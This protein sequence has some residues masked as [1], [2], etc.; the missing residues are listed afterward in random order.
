MST[1]ILDKEP[2]SVTT[3]DVY[4]E[5][6]GWGSSLSPSGRYFA[7]T[8]KSENIVLVDLETKE[9]RTIVE[10]TSKR[11]ED[12]SWEGGYVSFVSYSPDETEIAYGWIGDS[13]GSIRIVNAKTGAV[14]T[15]LDV[16]EY[17]TR[18]HDRHYDIGYSEAYALDW[19][20]DGSAILAFVNLTPKERDPD[21]LWRPL[22]IMVP[23]DGSTPHV[24]AKDKGMEKWGWM[25]A[26][27]AGGNDQYVMTAFGIQGQ[28]WIQ[29][30]DVKTGEQVPWRKEDDISI[31]GVACPAHEDKVV[32]VSEYLSTPYLM[33]GSVEEVAS[34]NTDDLITS[35]DSDRYQVPAFSDKGDLLIDTSSEAAPKQI[36]MDANPETGS[37]LGTTTIL[38]DGGSAGGWWDPSGTRFSWATVGEIKI[39]DKTTG[40][41][42]VL[43]V[44]GAAPRW[45]RWFPDGSK[46]GFWGTDKPLEFTFSTVYIETGEQSKSTLIEGSIIHTLGA[47]GNSLLV[48]DYFEPGP[49][50]ERVDLTTLE[51]S[52]YLCLE[53]DDS[54]ITK[55]TGSPDYSK[56]LFTTWAEES[57]SIGVVNAD[58]TNRR[59]VYEQPH[60]EMPMGWT[61]WF[62]TNY[63]TFAKRKTQ[64]AQKVNTIFK[65]DID[66]GKVAPIFE[67]ITSDMTVSNYSVSPDGKIVVFRAI[68]KQRV[69]SPEL[70]IMHKV[71]DEKAGN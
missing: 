46:I 71:L 22:L 25:G 6:E 30:I 23:L 11:L 13:K 9:Q 44:E 40:Q 69:E 52:P 70:F 51:R 32:Y 28:N 67:S 45:I 62:S 66:S 64:N 3:L 47:D 26:C 50:I 36:A 65:V 5:L 7:A 2:G 59:I 18:H 15:L 63:I 43:E 34:T 24:V 33:A 14:R 31:H 41:T 19:A 58:G 4:R 42:R 17:Y 20:K 55:I 60:S 16:N 12:G 56:Y 68:P 21:D 37:L 57:V 27:L 54:S 53:G 29:R 49:C 35:L 1:S 10:S 48:S 39:W 61:R 38:E 8:D